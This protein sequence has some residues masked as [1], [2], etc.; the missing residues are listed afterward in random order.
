MITVTFTEDEA[1]R[2]LA[3]LETEREK[4]VSQKYL[5]PEEVPEILEE[6]NVIRR[7]I[8]EKYQEA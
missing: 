2:I 3:A 5:F 8:E 7:K 1:L 6:I 4:T